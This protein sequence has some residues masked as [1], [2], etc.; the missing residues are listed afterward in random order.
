L[1]TPAVPGPTPQLAF[2]DDGVHPD[3]LPNDVIIP[4]L[5]DVPDGANSPIDPAYGA[6]EW[7]LKILDYLD[8]N[9][10][11]WDFFINTNNWCGDV[12]QDPACAGTIVRILTSQNPGNHTVHHLHM[13]GDSP[14]VEGVFESCDGPSSGTSCIPEIEG[15]EMVVDEL[16]KGGRPH[17]T[18]FRPPFGEPYFGGQGQG[19]AEQD[20]AK[21]SVA[22]G[23]SID[24]HD[25]D[26]NGNSCAK[27]PCPTGQGIADNVLKEIGA[28]PGSGQWGI[29]LMHGVFPW[30]YDAIRILF[31][32]HGNDGE[33]AKR[34]FRVG[35]VEDAICWRF[36][37]HS[38]QL[39]QDA[40]PGSTRSA[41]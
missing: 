24:S 31:G 4:T 33:I 22:V 9:Q 7:T 35:T 38:W 25:A 10:Q 37:K 40:N 23:W 16:S 34:G 13:G 20:V 6:G 39:V 18:R 27:K 1:G 3:Y 11:H 15:V 12:S 14:P 17:L 30:S 32:E 21:Y 2:E 8:Q 41:N 19:L 26:Y 5:D 36:G 29:V 28:A